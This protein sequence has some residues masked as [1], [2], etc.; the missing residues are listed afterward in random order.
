MAS[1]EML[2]AYNTIMH[3]WLQRF[4]NICS[5]IQERKEKTQGGVE[6][7]RKKNK[8]VF[9]ILINNQQLVKLN[10]YHKQIKKIKS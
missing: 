5:A 2:F 4:E 1:C 7:S 10:T 9:P 8:S 3:Q 6:E